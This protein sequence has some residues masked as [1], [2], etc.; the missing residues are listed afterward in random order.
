MGPYLHKAGRTVGTPQPGA[1]YRPLWLQSLQ[2][3]KIGTTQRFVRVVR[4]SL[5]Q[6]QEHVQ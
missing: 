1:T 6:Q 5:T 4:H 2:M 3:K